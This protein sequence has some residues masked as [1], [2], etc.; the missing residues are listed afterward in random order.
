M[1]SADINLYNQFY[2]QK[3]DQINSYPKRFLFVGR[4]E[5]VKAM[6]ILLDAW[7]LIESNRDGWELH[8]VE[9]APLVNL[10]KRMELLK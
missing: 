4:F 3:F 9:M 7:K 6:D 10:L 8:F 1:Y 2:E 5:N